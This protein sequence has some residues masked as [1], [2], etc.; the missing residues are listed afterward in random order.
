MYQTHVVH[1]RPK[2]S[3]LDRFLG[4]AGRTQKVEVP[5]HVLAMLIVSQLNGE[6]VTTFFAVGGALPRFDYHRLRH[7]VRHKNSR[8]I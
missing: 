2:H 1:Y 5:V 3:A 4:V 8:K 6:F 7:G